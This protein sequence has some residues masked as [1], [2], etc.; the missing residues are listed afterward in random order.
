MVELGWIDELDGETA[1]DAVAAVHRDELEIGARRL[2][3]AAHWADLH[4]GD[5]VDSTGRV[6]PGMETATRLGGPGTPKVL[7]FACAEFATLQGIHPAA[8]QNLI[9][10]SLNLRHRHPLLWARASTGQVRDWQAREV[11]KLVDA[12]DLDQAEAGFVDAATTRYIDTL[13][14]GRFLDLVA[15]KIIEADPEA[16]EACR[17]A[18]EADQFVRTGQS[19]EHGL[20]TLVAKANAG[21]VIWF[22]AMVNRIA[23]ILAG[24]GDTSPVDVRRAKA[25]GILANPARALGLLQSVVQT[26]AATGTSPEH[27]EDGEDARDS[28]NENQAD[29]ED[30]SPV[31]EGD[32][33]PSQNDADEPADDP[34]APPCTRCGSGDPTAFTR[35]D[36]SGIDPKKL[37]PP[38]T[39]YVHL[40]Q[41]SFTRDA[42]GVARF[43]GVGPI[44]VEQAR[45]FLRHTN[46]TI[47]PV[48]DLADRAPVDGYE[49]PDRLREAIHLRNPADVFPFATYTGRNTDMDHPIPYISP[50][51]G[52]P[53]HQTS[54]GNLAPLVRFHHRI[55][56]HGRWRLQE[57]EPGVYLWRSPHGWIYLV[58][59]SG[60]HPLGNSAT[61]RTL[62]MGAGQH[63]PH[64]RSRAE[65]T[66]AHDI[67][68]YQG[69][70]A[71]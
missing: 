54:M 45:D 26:P 14:W 6:L 49:V 57:P 31:G 23:L 35:T 9:R 64:A 40:S 41:D 3:L 52:G 56:T 11:A 59:D 25:I 68:D 36:L 48:I 13:P 61:A 44:T 38:V 10:D 22:M 43:E 51:D 15:A 28:A 67:L 65:V 27:A 24:H 5:A 29:G 30:V 20:K 63:D 50:D 42:D 17:L 70:H 8:G 69:D 7:E 21:D 19:N 34:A 62:W 60:T 46:V 53:P 71:A 33:H 4:N 18:A 12:A 66:A 39:L 55:K 2:R 47:K 1:C 16:A 58:D 37:L 32:L